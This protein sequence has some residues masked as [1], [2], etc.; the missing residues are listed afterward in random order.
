MENTKSCYLFFLCMNC[1][2]EFS[3]NK[4]RFD[5]QHTIKTGGKVVRGSTCILR[6]DLYGKMHNVRSLLT[7]LC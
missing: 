3:I 1:F 2:E 7:G 5:S 6:E 4:Q